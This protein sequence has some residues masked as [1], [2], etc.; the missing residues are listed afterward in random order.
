MDALYRQDN[1]EIE[2][3]AHNIIQLET[4]ADTIK[5]TFRLNMHNTLL[6]PVDRE[7]LL[8]PISDQDRLADTT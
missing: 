7:D 3:F 8:R 2:E 5:H 1:D 6:L 4:E